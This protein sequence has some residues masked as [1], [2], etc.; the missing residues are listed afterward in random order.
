[1]YLTRHMKSSTFEMESLNS[2]NSHVGH[3]N[4][5]HG[6]TQTKYVG[7][8]NPTYLKMIQMLIFSYLIKVIR[9]GTAVHEKFN[10]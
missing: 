4:L 9:F 1:M 2:Q 6:S 5:I 3:W 7:F 10:V 8:K